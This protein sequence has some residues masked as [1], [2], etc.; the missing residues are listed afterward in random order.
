MNALDVDKAVVMGQGRG[1]VDAVHTVA[2]S[3]QAAGNVPHDDTR[4]QRTHIEQNQLDNTCYSGTAD[5][6]EQHQQQDEDGT[7]D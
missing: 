4:Y 5:A 3:R 1:L 6:A 2:Q 7:G